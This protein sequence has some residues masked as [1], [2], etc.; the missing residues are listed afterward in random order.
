MATPTINQVFT[1][2]CPIKVDAD[3]A[4]RTIAFMTEFMNRNEDHA[5]FF[6]GT[7]LGVHPVR[8]R[9]QDR[10]HWLEELLNADVISLEDAL[11][12]LP[13]VN[14]DWLVTSDPFNLSC[15][16]LAHRLHTAHQLPERLREDAAVAALVMLQIRFMTGMMFKMFQH[17]ARKEV[18][19]ATYAT[20]NGK[21]DLKQYG[22]WRRV[23]EERAKSFLQ[24]SSIHANA[25]K[26]MD[27]DKRVLYVVTDMRTRVVANLK[28]IY[29][30]YLQVNSEN[31]TIRTK[32]TFVEH[33]GGD[34]LR[35][36]TGGPIAYTRYIKSIV[37]SHNSYIKQE[38]K[39]I[40]EKILPTMNPAM[41]DKTLTWI[42]N[43]YGMT[44]V[45]KF[46]DL[47]NDLMVYAFDYITSHRQLIRSDK[48][49]VGIID[50]LRGSIMS[51]RATDPRLIEL[52]SEFERV[53]TLATGNRNPNTISP[54]R[55]GV[56]LYTVGRAL[57]KEH[58]SQASALK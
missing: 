32:S 3:L 17:P 36:S 29:D 14:K 13:S 54:V 20:L 31:L 6:G 39:E 16:W 24:S 34:M 50:A 49:L 47:F 12:A 4:K 43:N 46:D 28:T 58:Y 44:H 35:E 41:L 21:F 11:H 23:L 30:I 19:E 53:V 9:D 2:Q 38:L 40:I 45:V 51:A 22:S 7:L 1:E 57:A 48:D 52:R 8:S 55:T 37:P 18:A 27:N 26:Y 33:D 15:V 42:S 25:F 10:V 5:S 56:M